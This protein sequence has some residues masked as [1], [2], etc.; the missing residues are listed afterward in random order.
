M[1]ATQFDIKFIQLI[2]Y[3][4]MYD[5][6]EWQKAQKFM[7]R[8]RVELQQALSSWSANLYEEALSRALRTKK[9]FL[10]VKL[11]RSEETKGSMK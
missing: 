1:L 10:K 4:L 7:S 3:V 8:L 5:A 6:N 11:I 2:K 9:N